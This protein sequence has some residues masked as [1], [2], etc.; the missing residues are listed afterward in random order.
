MPQSNPHIALLQ[1]KSTPLRPGMPSPATLLF[2]Y[3]IRGAMPPIN[4]P[5]GGVNND[6]EHYV[7]FVKDKQ[8]RIK[9]MILPEIMLPFQ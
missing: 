2:N 9:T 8:K 7:A 5:P 4:R 3:P 6:D 1:I